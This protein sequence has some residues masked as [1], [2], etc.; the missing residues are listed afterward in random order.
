MENSNLSFG[1]VGQH[2]LDGS[3]LLQEIVFL[4]QVRYSLLQEG[5]LLV[6]EGASS[7]SHSNRQDH[8]RKSRAEVHP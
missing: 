6:F 4:L 5:D 8:L 3:L 2:L 7:S 1:Q